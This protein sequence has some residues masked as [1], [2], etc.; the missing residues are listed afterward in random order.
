MVFAYTNRG[1]KLQ[2]NVDL[3][4]LKPTF[5][6]ILVVLVYFS[7]DYRSWW[8][9]CSVE[10]L[11]SRQGLIPSQAGV[12]SFEVTSVL[13]YCDR[14]TLVHTCSHKL[15]LVYTVYI[16]IL[17]YFEILWTC[18]ITMILNVC[19]FGTPF[20]IRNQ[21]LAETVFL[22]VVPQ[23][24]QIWVEHRHSWIVLTSGCQLAFS[25]SNPIFKPHWVWWY[26]PHELD[27]WM[28]LNANNNNELF[29]GPFALH[30]G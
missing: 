19:L 27:G 29:V 8:I 11:F 9:C 12:W 22:Q 13:T 2:E 28:M 15:Y 16:S 14:Q 24:H 21:H 5:Q 26:W 10:T 4:W 18:M 17:H 7:H 25:G 6:Y 23:S 30:F 3:R 20:V 1:V